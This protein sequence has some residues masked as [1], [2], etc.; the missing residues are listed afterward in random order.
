MKARPKE[1]IGALDRLAPGLGGIAR[2]N[3]GPMLSLGL[4][5]IGQP[6]ELEG[7][8]AYAIALRFQDGAVFLG[9]LKVGEIPPLF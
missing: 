4:A 5:F 9:P 7:K 6:T 8:R 1:S 3:A 2:Q